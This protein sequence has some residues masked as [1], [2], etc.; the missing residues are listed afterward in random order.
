MRLDS[1][2][3]FETGVLTSKGED[4]PKEEFRLIDLVD[5]L[6]AGKNVFFELVYRVKDVMTKNVKTLMMD[7][8]I[9][10][11]LKFMEENHVRHIPIVDKPTGEEETP[12]FSAG[13]APAGISLCG[14]VRADRFGLAGA[15]AASCANRDQRSEVRIA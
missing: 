1:L 13:C 12:C 7:G 3:V 8:T 2:S 11:C 4:M 14:E 15:E 6:S 9:E 5:D 10:K